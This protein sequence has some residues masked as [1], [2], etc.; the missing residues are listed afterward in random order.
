LRPT[1]GKIL[2]HIS[3]GINYFFSILQMR[4]ELGKLS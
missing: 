1:K 2:K 3:C 4:T